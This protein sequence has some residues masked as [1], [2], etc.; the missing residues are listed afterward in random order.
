M[1]LDK[2]F[3]IIKSKWLNYKKNSPNKI[4]KKKSKE[5]MNMNTKTPKSKY[6]KVQVRIMNL[7]QT[8][9]QKTQNQ[10]VNIQDNQEKLWTTRKLEFF[11]KNNYLSLKPKYQMMQS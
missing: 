2:I 4:G 3:M 9:R 6:M 10:L 11:F 5:H 8:K 1:T 7:N